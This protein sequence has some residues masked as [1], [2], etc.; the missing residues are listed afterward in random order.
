MRDGV[1]YEEGTDRVIKKSKI[2]FTP[3]IGGNV[4]ASP[5]YIS[6]ERTGIKRVRLD[7]ESSYTEEEYPG[8]REFT[9]LFARD[10]DFPKSQKMVDQFLKT[11][12]PAGIIIKDILY[13]TISSV[14]FDDE[15]VILIGD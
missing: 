15:V 5:V 6:D 13:P 12:I 9:Y 11:N 2:E 3:T 7:V 14:V 10:K 1:W 4:T 8:L